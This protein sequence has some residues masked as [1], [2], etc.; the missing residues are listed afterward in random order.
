MSSEIERLK[1]LLDQTKR[2]GEDWR[3]R[4]SK[5]EISLNE[6]RTLEVRLRDLEQ[7]N[8]ILL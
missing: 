1:A 5:L 6:S 3:M 8:Q 4:S 7:R 2:E